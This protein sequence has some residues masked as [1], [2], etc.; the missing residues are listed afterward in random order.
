MIL[1]DMGWP[2]KEKEEESTGLAF[3]TSHERRVSILS[4]PILSYP[5]SILLLFVFLQQW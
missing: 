5:V 4:D 1:D 3:G 2:K